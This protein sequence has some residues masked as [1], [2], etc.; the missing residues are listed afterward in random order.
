[1]YLIIIKFKICQNY[2]S[3]EKNLKKAATIGKFS[4]DNKINNKTIS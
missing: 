4:Y 2:L 3:I 1:M